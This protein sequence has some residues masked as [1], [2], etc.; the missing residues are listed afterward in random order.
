LALEIRKLGDPVLREKC[1]D[2]EHIDG[3]VRRLAKEM[4]RMVA[5]EEG[6]AGL[7]AS[8]VGVLKSLFVYNFGHGPRCL[9]NPMIFDSGEIIEVEEGCLSIPGVYVALPRHDRVRASC[10][11]L[12]GH[13]IEVEMEGFPAQVMQ[14]ECDHLNGILIIDRCCAEERRRAL[15]EY[16]ELELRREQ[17]GV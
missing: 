8:Q 1:R 4:G 2:V 15:D 6:R 14:H 16:Q 13:E 11:T 7:A 9:L 12:S 10:M 17:A 5:E 3:E